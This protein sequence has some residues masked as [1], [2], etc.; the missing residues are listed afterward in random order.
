MHGAALIALT[1]QE[2]KR[3]SLSLTQTEGWPQ[4]RL[5][6]APGG[7]KARLGGHK[8]RPGSPAGL[9]RPAPRPPHRPPGRPG[10]VAAPSAQRRKARARRPQ[11][12]ARGPTVPPP[13]ASAA[14]S[15]AA[16]PPPRGTA[17]PCRSRSR[18]PWPAR[19]MPGRGGV[20]GRS[21]A[22]SP[23][24]AR[25]SE[26]ASVRL[27]FPL[28]PRLIHQTA[29]PSFRSASSLASQRARL[30][31]PHPSLRWRPRGVCPQ[32]RWRG[33]R[34]RSSPGY[35]A[36]CGTPG[37]L[38]AGP[39]RAQSCQNGRLRGPGVGR[40]EGRERP[41]PPHGPPAASRASP[42]QR[43]GAPGALQRA[44]A[45]RRLLPFPG[46]IQFIALFRPHACSPGSPPALLRCGSRSWGDGA[47]RER[48]VLR[49][50][51]WSF[52]WCGDAEKLLS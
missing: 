12:A 40:G 24:G 29:A 43:C 33:T 51:E 13:A 48:L 20:D 3:G 4:P 47:W 45:A 9:H 41:P 21:R 32:P 34:F 28:F 52:L 35:G 30:S 18:P 25:Y 38:R 11:P 46:P 49:G 6:A 27:S 26:A 10:A 15:A 44:R 22:G 5:S 17:V 7:Y 1:A 39:G 23:R 37:V 19:R 50:A 16:P 8:T 14:P 31:R 2:R 42:A 36:R